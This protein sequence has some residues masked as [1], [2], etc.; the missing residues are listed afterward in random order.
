TDERTIREVTSSLTPDRALFLVASKSG[1]TVEFS[2]RERHLWG[3]MTDKI[4]DKAGRHFAAITDPATSLAA[5]AA[6]RRYRHTFLN[7]AD[8]G[9]RYSALS[10]FGLVPAAL[11][12]ID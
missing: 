2:S 3:C 9:G 10:L 12:G 11:L 6:E 5:L 1:S 4:G 7:P 8:I